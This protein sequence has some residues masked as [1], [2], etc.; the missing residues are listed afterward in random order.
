MASLL[1]ENLSPALIRSLEYSAL[2]NR[3]SLSEEALAILVSVLAPEQKA[4]RTLPPVFQGRLFL[5]QEM[6]D[7]AMNK[8]CR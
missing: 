6:L 8:G 5:T 2:Q 1:I 3:R 4:S 7:E